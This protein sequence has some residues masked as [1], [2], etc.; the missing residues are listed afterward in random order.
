[1]GHATLTNISRLSSR[2]LRRKN[3]AT[4]TEIV[5]ELERRKQ[6][7]HASEGILYERHMLSNGVGDYIWWLLAKKLIV[8]EGMTRKQKTKFREW[9]TGNCD[10]WTEKDY[11]VLDSIRW[12]TEKYSL[13]LLH[14]VT[15]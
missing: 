8:Q 10:T 12:R 6:G 2:M 3:G 7:V 9:T 1:M 14:N 15:H 4:V 13:P 5:D 11:A